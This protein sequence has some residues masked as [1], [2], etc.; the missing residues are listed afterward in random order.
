MANLR[1]V[2]KELSDEL[3]EFQRGNVM[4]RNYSKIVFSVRI[5]KGLTQ[6]QLASLANVSVKTIHRLESGSGGITDDT[7]SKVFEA[8]DLTLKDVADFFREGETEGH[9]KTRG[10]IK[11]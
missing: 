9:T 2:R 7:Y 11:S 10:L 3:P 5:K 6:K 1:R 4:S 8:L